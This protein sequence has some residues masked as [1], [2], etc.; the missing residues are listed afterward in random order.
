MVMLL[1]EQATAKVA[2][3]MG[4]VVV[5]VAM[6][7]WAAVMME[8]ASGLEFASL[9]VIHRGNVCVRVSSGLCSSDIWLFLPT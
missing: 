8:E 2:S 9:S 7:E 5:K 4:K 6:I 3:L 1:M